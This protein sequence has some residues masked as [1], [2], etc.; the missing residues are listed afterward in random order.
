MAAG[1]GVDVAQLQV[2]V[3]ESALYPTVTLLGNVQHLHDVPFSGLIPEQSA[4][5]ALI[6]VAI[7]LYQ[8]GAEYSAIRQSKETLAQRRL[9]LT[10]TRDKARASVVEV[11]GEIRAAKAQMKAAQEQ[12]RAA[13]VAL[14]GMRMEARLALRTTLDVL[15]TQQALVN[16]QVSLVT[17]QHDRVV[18][19]YKLLSAVGRL[20][21]QTLGLPTS[22]YEPVVH[23]QQVRD[24]WRGARTPDGR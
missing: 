20:S 23:Y 21:P 12:V 22:I 14:N 5:T 6:T 1:Y 16:A 4:A 18:G 19:S 7:P 8:G 3:S 2:K 15:I 11:W 10:A 9:D 13:E 17:A 24:A